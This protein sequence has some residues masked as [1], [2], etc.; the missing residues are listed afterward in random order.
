MAS[1][2]TAGSGS[3]DVPKSL[4]F[5]FYCPTTE[6]KNKASGVVPGPKVLVLNSGD[7][8][9]GELRDLNYQAVGPLLSRRA[10]RVTSQM[11]V[12]SVFVLLFS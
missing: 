2:T 11:E 6:E 7:E 10:K 12:R 1:R 4:P 8:M 9:F 3:V 5:H